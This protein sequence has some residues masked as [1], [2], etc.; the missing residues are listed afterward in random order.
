[1]TFAEAIDRIT[2]AVDRPDL[3]AQYL[4]F[5]NRAVR[6]TANR[7]EWDQLK[8]STEI[9]MPAGQRTRVLPSDF[10]AWQ[11]GRFCVEIYTTGTDNEPTPVPVY[12][13]G[14][15]ERL[16]STFR[17]EN[18]LVFT[19]DNGGFQVRFPTA[20]EDPT[21][22]V[23][24]YF[25]F[26]AEVSDTSQTTALLR[27][28][29]NMVLSKALSLVFQSINDP[30]YKTHEQQWEKEIAIATGDDIRDSNPKPDPE[31]E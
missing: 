28:Y 1:M 15:L 3:A 4:S 19:Q 21:T 26:P 20:T 8:V 24:H 27:D 9:T 30:V 7:H 12:T 18:Y 25:A 11:N 6:E 2:V 5:L 10:K 29:P 22:L 13:R 23:L 16:V 31:K 14:D 17:P